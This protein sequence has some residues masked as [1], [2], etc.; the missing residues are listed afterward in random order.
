MIE[1]LVKTR[2]AFTLR[3]A[4]KK[5]KRVATSG[6][7]VADDSATTGSRESTRE[8]NAAITATTQGEG[9]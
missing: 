9:E 7:S 1:D 2:S 5:K 6:K 3:S 8:Q 4:P